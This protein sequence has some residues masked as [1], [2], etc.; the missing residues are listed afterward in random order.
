MDKVSVLKK[1]EGGLISYQILNIM[2][3][4][5]IC[6]AINTDLLDKNAY[7]IEI[8][9]TFDFINFD[10]FRV[11]N[12]RLIKVNNINDVFFSNLRETIYYITGGRIYQIANIRDYKDLCEKYD[13]EYERNIKRKILIEKI[14]IYKGYNDWSKN[15]S[16]SN[17]RRFC[18]DK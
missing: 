1:S 8:E 13:I 3:I 4:K 5:F 12:R 9:K 14:D 6:N 15:N 7:L 16:N 17:I 2:A 18:F 10:Y 11:Y